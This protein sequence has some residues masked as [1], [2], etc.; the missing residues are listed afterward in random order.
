MLNFLNEM[1]KLQVADLVIPLREL[2]FADANVAYHLWVLVFP[3]VW[4]ALHKEEQVILTKPMIALLS[5]DYHKR[6]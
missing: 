6:Q 5:K 4:V 2:A 1:S 3:I